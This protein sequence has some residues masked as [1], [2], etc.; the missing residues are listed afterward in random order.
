MLGQ[1]SLHD[2][3]ES[4]WPAMSDL[5]V[6]CQVQLDHIEIHYRGTHGQAFKSPIS[7]DRSYLSCLLEAF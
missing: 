5:Q 2:P 3:F 4:T 6:A 7:Q 1:L